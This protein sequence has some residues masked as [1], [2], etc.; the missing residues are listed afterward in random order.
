VRRW[1]NGLVEDFNAE[2]EDDESEFN[3]DW[4]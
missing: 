2:R 1:V 3:P 4:D